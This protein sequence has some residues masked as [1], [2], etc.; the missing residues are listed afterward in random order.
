MQDPADQY[1]IDNDHEFEDDSDEANY[2][3]ADA[4]EEGQDDMMYDADAL[5]SAGWGTDEDYGYFPDYETTDWGG[6]A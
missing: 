1:D 4:A 5:A 2:E 6:G 3:A